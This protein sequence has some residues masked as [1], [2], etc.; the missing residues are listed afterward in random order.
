MSTGALTLLYT[1]VSAVS[2]TG[3]STGPFKK[4]PQWQWK[5]STEMFFL[6]KQPLFLNSQLGV[7]TKNKSI[8][9]IVRQDLIWSSNTESLPPCSFNIKHRVGLVRGRGAALCLLSN[10]EMFVLCFL[11]SF[12]V[13]MKRIFV[14]SLVVLVFPR[15]RFFSSTSCLWRSSDLVAVGRVLTVTGTQE[16][17]MCAERSCQ[18]TVQ[19]LQGFRSEST[20]L[21]VTLSRGFNLFN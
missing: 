16:R 3:G 18:M 17:W 6:E 12:F 4:S 11:C 8:W 13:Y 5:T 9:L 20:H 21:L 2:H 14:M 15:V 19:T 1:K 7:K 10:L